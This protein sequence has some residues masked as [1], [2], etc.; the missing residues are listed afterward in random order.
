MAHSDGPRTLVLEW[1]RGTAPTPAG[2]WACLRAAR[3]ED[4]ETL[5]A[6]HRQEAAH[7]QPW[8]VAWNPQ[9]GEDAWQAAALTG[10]KPSTW[11]GC[12][13]VHCPAVPVPQLGGLITLER[14]SGRSVQAHPPDPPLG[15]L[16]PGGHDS[17]HPMQAA[18][19]AVLLLSYSLAR[20]WEGQGLMSAALQA[21]R[22]AAQPGPE[23]GV[24]W[25]AHVREDNRRSA[26]LLLRL[27]MQDTGPDPE[28]PAVPTAAGWRRHHRWTGA[29]AA[30]GALAS[31]TA[32]QP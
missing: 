28:F 10:L 26:A 27:G 7:L 3:L 32:L 4:A 12:I 2:S 20:A 22:C 29:G 23:G 31:G 1:P 15:S 25:W 21:L 13:W 17:Q 9:R 6:Y 14:L 16:H 5:A 19:P 18:A 8:D 11:W 24:Q 30:P